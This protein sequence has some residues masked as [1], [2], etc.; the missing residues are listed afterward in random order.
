MSRQTTQS[1]LFRIAAHQQNSCVRAK[2]SE[3]VGQLVTAF[4][5]QH[6]I[7]KKQVD[8]FWASVLSFKCL[9]RTSGTDKP[10]TRRLQHFAGYFSY[11]LLIF[12]KEDSFRSTGLAFFGKGHTDDRFCD[13][14]RRDVRRMLLPVRLGCAA[15][16]LVKV[17][18]QLPASYLQMVSTSAAI[19]HSYELIANDA[20]GATMLFKSGCLQM[21]LASHAARSGIRAGNWFRS[22][23]TASRHR[24][25][26]GFASARTFA[27]LL[28]TGQDGSV[29]IE[30]EF[31]CP[32][33]RRQVKR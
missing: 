11:E 6:D 3:F 27:H 5:W 1:Q 31:V 4:S 23:K 12:D 15:C 9:S 32:E 29:R 18:I 13:C 2:S 14:H 25:A 17:Q 7:R 28:W 22:G 30:Q 16:S 20:P 21:V 19:M 26:P 33:R 10:V 24:E 8:W